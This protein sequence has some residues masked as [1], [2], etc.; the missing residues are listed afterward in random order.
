MNTRSVIAEMSFLLFGFLLL[1]LFNGLS[2][3]Q[4]GL[5]EDVRG[6]LEEIMSW[7]QKMNGLDITVEELLQRVERMEI[8]ES[9]LESQSLEM[10]NFQKQLE[11]MKEQFLKQIKE[12]ER[13]MENQCR[14]EVKK[15]VEKV[16]PTAV[17]QRLRDL[18]FEKVCAH[19]GSWYTENSVITYD[20][21]S[22]EFKNSDRPG[23][24]FVHIYPHT[25]LAQVPMDR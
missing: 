25:V 23:G 10:E 24:L 18:P 16:L 13:K 2:S 14:A 11:E 6:D 7:S 3:K 21:I 1:H 19:K 22:I 8:L 5:E 9:K 20:R 17:E 15:E 4:S 12:N